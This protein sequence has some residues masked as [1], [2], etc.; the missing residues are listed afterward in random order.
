MT[1]DEFAER[2]LVVPYVR[3]GRSF[4]GW[5]CWGIVYCAYLH[6][7]GLTIN[8]LSDEYNEDVSLKELMSIVMSEADRRQWSEVEKPEPLDIGVY[9]VGPY[10]SHVSLV[11]EGGRMLHCDNDIG[12]V[13][14]R[15]ENLVWSKRRIGYFR[16]QGYRSA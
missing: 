7:A 5:D 4:D 6:V 12:S 14:E 16:Y 13:V 2:A 3:G 10:Y 11:L 15:L 1:I 9:R 8:S